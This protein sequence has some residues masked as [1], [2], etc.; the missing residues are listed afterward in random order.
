MPAHAF[1]DLDQLRAAAGTHLGHS[2]WLLVDQQR[3]DTF[4][5]ATGDHQWIHVDQER[6][7]DGPFG[8]TIAHG[9]LT[10]SLLPALVAS[11]VEYSGWRVKVNYGSNK[12]RFPAPVPVGSRVRAGLTILAVDETSAGTQVTSH[13]LVEVESADGVRAL[14]PALVAEIITLLA[15]PADSS[16]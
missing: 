10:L 5:E 7:A 2:E 16:P 6:A 3:V 11:L 1:R 8:T 14:K 9:Y 15:D 12:V 4:A 13:V